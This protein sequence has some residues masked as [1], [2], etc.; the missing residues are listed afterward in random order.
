MKMI[1][2]FI[3]IK[4]PA[5]IIENISSFQQKLKREDVFIKWVRP[6]SIHITLKFLGE[7][8]KSLVDKIG[9][10]IEIAV[11]MLNPFNIDVTGTGA[12]PNLK[13]PKVVWIGAKS[14]NN[15]LSILASTLSSIFMF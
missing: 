7:I 6:E 4:I 12:F 9:T 10:G 8:D 15:I 2:T 1:R 13:R 14:E 11:E 3:A 5:Q